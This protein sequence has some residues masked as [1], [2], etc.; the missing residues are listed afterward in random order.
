MIIPNFFIV[1]APKCGTTALSYY[2]KSHPNIFMSEPKEPH[3]F[4]EDLPSYRHVTNMAEYQKLF[5]EAGRGTLAMGEASVFYLYSQVAISSIRKLVPNAKLIVM[6]RDPAEI[7]VSMHAQALVSRDETVRSFA[8]AWRLCEA[9]RNG[10]KVPR[11][12]RDAKILLY[13]SLPLLGEQLR[14]L[15]AQ[16]PRSQVRWWFLDE[17]TDNPSRVYQEVLEFLEVPYDGRVDF[18]KI[19]Q[20]RLA[21]NQ[22]I[23]EFTQKTPHVL[24]SAAMILKNALGIE[25]LGILDRIRRWNFT[26]AQ[27]G[28]YPTEIEAEV[29][30][31][32][33]HDVGIL[34]DITGEN[35]SSWKCIKGI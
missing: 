19:N 34:E 31:H 32:F 8:S 26:A 24:I 15:L 9:R 16:F 1:G 22:L 23:A 3:F 10:L 21:K 25:K 13:D 30:R 29:R 6:L 14:R 12:C 27:G 5:G 18:P 2:L 28:S 33:C 17:L 20:R 4:A 7:A 35:L 11:N